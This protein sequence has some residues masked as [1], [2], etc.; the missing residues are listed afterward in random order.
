LKPRP[1][2]EEEPVE[3]EAEP[4]EVEKVIDLG[5]RKAGTPRMLVT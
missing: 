2:A 5:L 1:E 3:A 4:V